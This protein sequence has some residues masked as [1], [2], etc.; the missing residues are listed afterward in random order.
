MRSIACDGQQ[1]KGSGCPRERS[2]HLGRARCLCSI[3]DPLREDRE[4]Y[5]SAPS[6]LEREAHAVLISEQRTPWAGPFGASEG[7]RRAGVTW[8]PTVRGATPGCLQPRS[9]LRRRPWTALT[10]G[11][12]RGNIACDA[13]WGR[14]WR[15][16]ASADAWQCAAVGGPARA[17]R[18]RQLYTGPLS[19]ILCAYMHHKHWRTSTN[20]MCVRDETPLYQSKARLRRRPL[21]FCLDG[22][23]LAVFV[24]P[25]SALGPRLIWLP[26]RA[27]LDSP[28]EP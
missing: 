25:V 2:D 5:L 7:Q 26:F 3:A 18:C 13:G 1:E 8:M 12:Q 10:A 27:H 17:Y 28:H 11:Q 6:S 9:P 16:L 19:A 14:L 4:G 22:R 20:R 24:Q 23:F 15:L 21:P